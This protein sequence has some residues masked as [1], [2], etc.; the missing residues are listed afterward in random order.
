[1]QTEAIPA[2]E[3]LRMVQENRINDGKSLAALMLA[4]GV[5]ENRD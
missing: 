3:A 2:A 5:L 4:R 1:L